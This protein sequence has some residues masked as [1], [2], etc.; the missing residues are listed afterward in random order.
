MPNRD[1][2]FARDEIAPSWWPNRIQAVLSTMTSQLV[3]SKLNNTTIQVVASAGDGLVGI[4]IGG[5]LRYIEAT[6]SQAHPGGAAATFDIYATCAENAID[7]IPAVNTDH[8]NFAF[9]LQ[10]KAL[11]TP[12]TIVPGTVDFYRK[13]GQLVWDGAAIRSITQ[14]VGLVPQAQGTEVGMIVAYAGAGD[15]PVGQGG[16]QWLLADGRLVSKTTYAEFFARAGHVYNLGVDPGGGNVKIPDKRGR[17]SVGADDMT[18]A[19][20]VGVSPGAAGRLPNSNRVIGQ[21][22][23]EERHTMTAAEMVAH[24][25]GVSDPTHRHGF[26]A[27]NDLSGAFATPAYATGG[28]QNFT[29]YSGTGISLASAGGG[30]AYNVMHNYECDNMI[31]RVA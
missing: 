31:V 24:G 27:S 13:I 10:I 4:A 19:R 29:N 21:N 12:P 25:H 17:S 30:V 22:G 8:T 1:H 23:G 15:P 26:D 18:G 2:L 16:Q 3:I 7:N 11:A 14:L 6:I 5:K 20:L 28:F 9:A